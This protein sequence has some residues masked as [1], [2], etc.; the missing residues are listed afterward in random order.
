MYD[1]SNPN[2]APTPWYRRSSVA[3]TW[4]T[5]VGFLIAAISGTMTWRDC[6]LASCIAVLGASTDVFFGPESYRASP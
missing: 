1:P 6:G 5:I 4:K 2:V 3:G